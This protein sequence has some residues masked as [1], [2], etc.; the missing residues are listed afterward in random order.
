MR[1]ASAKKSCGSNDK[2]CVGPCPG[3]G[4][5]SACPPLIVLAVLGAERVVPVRGAAR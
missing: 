4:T 1:L 2:S 3:Y 5:Q